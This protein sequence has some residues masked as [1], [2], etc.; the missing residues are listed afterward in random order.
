MEAWL[1]LRGERP[2]LAAGSVEAGEIEILIEA[3]ASLHA[4]NEAVLLWAP[5]HIETAL[6]LKITLEKRGFRARLRSEKVVIES[7]KPGEIDVL[8]L[9]SMGELS[10]LYAR[11]EG[12]FV[13]GTFAGGGHNVLEP[14]AGGRP[15]VFGPKR[16]FFAAEQE[17]CE[18]NEVGISVQNAA[19]LAGAWRKM[20]DDQ[21][22]RAEVRARIADFIEAGQKSW[23]LSL[24][25]LL[26][27]FDALSNDIET[28]R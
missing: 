9:D 25:L 1:A 17:M 2:L 22:Y 13:G 12:A 24:D 18:Q 20:L 15:V 14:L 11:C 28:G 5:R 6:E 19:E 4:R 27:E 21:T 16:G 10:A 7:E 8:I 26:R 23:G 3:F